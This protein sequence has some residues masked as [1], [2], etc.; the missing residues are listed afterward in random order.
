MSAAGSVQCP[1]D[2]CSTDVVMPMT[3]LATLEHPAALVIGHG[4][5]EE[6][7]LR[8]SVVQVVIDDLVAEDLP[9][10]AAALEPVGRVAQRVR[11]ALDVGLVRVPLECRPELELIL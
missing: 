10:G 7:L 5:V 6:P 8:P 3:G 11:E 1:H 9:R 4:L 2:A